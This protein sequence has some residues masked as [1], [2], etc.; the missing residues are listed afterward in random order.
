M[1]YQLKLLKP[2]DYKIIELF[3][4]WKKEEQDFELYTCRHVKPIDTLDEYRETMKKVFESGNM[5]YYLVS[6][7][8]EVLGKVTLFDLNTRN[9]SAEFGYYF[10]KGNRGKG[11]GSLLIGKLINEILKCPELKLNKLYATTA[12][13]NLGSI[14]LLKKF[15]F[16]LDGVMREHIWL[17][18]ER[19]DQ[20]C[21]SLLKSEWSNR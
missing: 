16:K 4:Q 6:D 1:T 21:Y 19:Q 17:K 10:P 9:K 3:H 20:H 11:Y 2:S 15:E 18:N 5:T 7:K 14:A 13:G 12:S 8:D